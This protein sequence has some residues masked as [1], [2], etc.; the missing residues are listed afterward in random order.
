MNKE[1]FRMTD[2]LIFEALKYVLPQLKGLLEE[3]MD[4]VIADKMNI[5]AYYPGNKINF[6]LEVGKALKPSQPLYHAINEGRCLHRYVAK[7]V[8]GIEFKSTVMPI[9]NE[10][11]QV[12]GAMGIGKSLERQAEM[13]ETAALLFKSLE[14][15]N[16][17]LDEISRGSMEFNDKMNDIIEFTKVSED[18]IKNSDEILG[19]LE[20]IVAQ[21]HLLGLNAYIEAARSGDAGKGFSIVAS[22]IRKLS[23]YTGASLN[24]ILHDLDQI[25]MVNDG[26]YKIIKKMGGISEKQATSIETV[27]AKLQEITSIA[28]I[29]A[30]NKL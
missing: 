14:E 8:H 3:D 17:N 2:D 19:L 6:A 24:R 13:K 11:G 5:L 16:K 15:T 25:K 28:Q 20:N 27:S 21:T 9:R 12:I 7:E 10:K 23:T 30:E 29:L 4:V 26:M 1:D 18:K 22:E